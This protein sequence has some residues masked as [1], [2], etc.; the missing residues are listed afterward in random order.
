MAQLLMA[1]NHPN[2]VRCYDTFVDGT[3]MCIVMELCGEGVCWV[4]RHVAG[5][6]AVSL[7][8]HTVTV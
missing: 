6:S 4:L 5:D 7:G 3:K 2:I 1:L 8:V